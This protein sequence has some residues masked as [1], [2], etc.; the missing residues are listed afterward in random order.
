LPTQPENTDPGE[1]PTVK[2]PPPLS[3]DLWD[4]PIG[5][6]MLSNALFR[7]ALEIEPEMADH[8][9]RFAALKDRLRKRN[10][11]IAEIRYAVDRLADDPD[12][13]EHLRY[14]DSHLSAGDFR[15][16]IGPLRKIRSKLQGE[17]LG[18]KRAAHQTGDDGPRKYRP[19]TEEEVEQAVQMLPAVTFED[20]GTRKGENDETVYMLTAEKREEVFG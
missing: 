16:V 8:Q 5:E 4:Q 6:E 11:S 19:L 20:F 9:L 3:S 7:L 12:L 14:P 2:D 1:L 18:S 13:I 17:P 15:R 10:Y